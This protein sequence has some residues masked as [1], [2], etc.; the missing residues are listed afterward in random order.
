E[1]SGSIRLGQVGR[2]N[3]AYDR[4]ANKADVKSKEAS[5]LRKELDAK[6]Q[7]NSLLRRQIES[8]EAEVRKLKRE[9]SENDEAFEEM[10]ST[11][12]RC[13]FR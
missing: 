3:G 6:V 1:K 9:R 7:E 12:R 4:L 13:F 10:L 5:V 2:F 8:L 11:G